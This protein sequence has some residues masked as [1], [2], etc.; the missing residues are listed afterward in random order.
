MKRSLLSLLGFALVLTA[1]GTEPGTT[2]TTK[3]DTTAAK[4]R[5]ATTTP[6]TKTE[7]PATTSTPATT[8]PTAA[9]TSTT[10]STPAPEKS[11]PLSIAYDGKS[12]TI[13]LNFE[14]T[15]TDQY[16]LIE[17]RKSL[18]DLPTTDWQLGYGVKGEGTSQK[19]KIKV[20]SP[21][22]FFRLAKTDSSYPLLL[23]DAD[24]DG[25]IIGTTQ[26]IPEPA[27]YALLLVGLALLAPLLRRS[28]K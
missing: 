24:G 15:E 22:G 9:S 10:P 27:T 26:C 19:A 28:P 7:T 2:P 23:K 3:T 11:L 5:P 20:S 25:I 14:A 8:T 12:G 21:T 1:Y 4:T 16:Y 13:D 17:G 6:S 18:E